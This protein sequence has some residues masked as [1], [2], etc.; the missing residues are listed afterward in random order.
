MEEFN[1]FCNATSGDG[2]VDCSLEQRKK[3][4]DE[5]IS[6]KDEDTELI[7][8]FTTVKSLV[9]QSY[10]TSQFFLTNVQVYELIPGRYQGC[11]S[12]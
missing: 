7:S 6:K 11:V 3:I 12:I 1:Q 5:I 8:F 9:I 10:T 2:F 4:V